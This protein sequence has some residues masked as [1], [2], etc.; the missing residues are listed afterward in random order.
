M[1][2]TTF[3][4]W[5]FALFF[6]FTAPWVSAVEAGLRL[7]ALDCGTLEL[8][9][10][11]LFE[12]TDAYAGVPGKMA[13][14]CFLVRH[15]QGDLI[16]DTGLGDRLAGQGAVAMAPGITGRVPV[17]LRDQLQRLEL[18]PAD[19]EFVSFSHLHVDHT[20]NAPLFT[21]STFLFSRAG[22]DWALGEP[23]PFGVDPSALDVPEGAAL[24]QLD[25]DFDV[26]G[27]G[28]VRILRAPGHTPG[29]RVLMLQLPAA[30][31]VILS[32]DLYHTRENFR[33]ARI[34]AINT[35]R[36]ETLASFERISKLIEKHSARFVIQ[37]AP[38]DFAALP[39]FPAYLD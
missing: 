29:H 38:D 16:W 27:D 6:P 13:V 28:S 1:S 31:T 3:A 8:E 18:A 26:F 7:Y 30:D 32:G 20:G 35:S 33:H 21:D 37:H 17:T 14:P 24:R 19:I 25:L 5:F 22:R 23:T 12:D 11:A 39:E 34:P 36:A 2:R 15:P 4:A 9:D 10:M